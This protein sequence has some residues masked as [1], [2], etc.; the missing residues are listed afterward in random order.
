ME[1][2]EAIPA[3]DAIADARTL[4]ANVQPQP[5]TALGKAL[6]R[7][8]RAVVACLDG[9]ADLAAYLAREAARAAFKAVRG[10]RG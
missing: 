6:D 3:A 7:G 9:K 8:S 1:R 2:S 10:L 4:V 5:W